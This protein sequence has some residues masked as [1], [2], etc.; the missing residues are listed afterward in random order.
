[1][2]KI[3]EAVELIQ[4]KLLGWT[5]DFVQM[6]PNLA[7]AAVIVVIGWLLA[8]LARLVVRKVLGRWSIGPTL[9]RLVG[10][11]IYLV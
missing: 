2:L 6:L 7:V 9:L 8:R 4:Q 10:N 1:M 11:S 3:T 5:K